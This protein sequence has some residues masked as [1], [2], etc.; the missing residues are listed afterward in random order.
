MAILEPKLAILD[1]TDS[2]LDIDAL[3]VVAN[4]VNALRSK[5][6]AMLV[7]THH[8]RLLDYIVPDRVHVMAAGRIVRS[9][10]KDL[11][12]ELEENGYTGLGQQ[13][14]AG[15]IPVGATR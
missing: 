15:R 10:D 4:G 5:G 7:I 14:S 13:D 6:R 3:R 1:E 8:Q 2:G 12:V 9:G 11:A